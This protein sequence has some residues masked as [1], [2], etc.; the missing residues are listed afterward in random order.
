MGSTGKYHVAIR[1]IVGETNLTN[2]GLR[3]R[4]RLEPDSVF[5]GGL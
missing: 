1:Y 3:A 5:A 2:D 4:I